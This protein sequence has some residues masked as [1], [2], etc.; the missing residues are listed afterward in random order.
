[1]KIVAFIDQSLYAPSVVDHAIWL[2]RGR[3]ARVEPV[4]I[5][6][7]NELMAAQVAPMHPSVS[8]AVD[9]A[10]VNAR[11]EEL[12]RS[13]A[14]Q[15]EAACDRLHEAGVNNVNGRLL[16]GN[17]ATSMLEAAANASVVVM[18]KRGESADLARLPLGSQV[19]RLVRATHVPVLAVSRSFRPVERMML[20]MDGGTS[21][22][23]QALAGGVLP[24]HGALEVLHVGEATEPVQAALADAVEALGRA[25]FTVSAQRIGGE[26]RLAI[27]ERVVLERIDLMA[28]GAFGSPRL[29]SMLLG[30]LTTELLRACQIPILLC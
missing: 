17:I 8:L 16:E 29:K 25:G 10:R 26:A 22:A 12:K 7:P 9:G 24:A 4:Q 18:G 3:S 23:V 14:E 30:S 21:P 27:P 2:A 15:L 5:V 11:V 28:M 6:S 19:E 1:M 20:P 13:G